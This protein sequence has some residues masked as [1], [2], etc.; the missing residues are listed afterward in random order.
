MPKTHPFVH[1]FSPDSPPQIALT[2]VVSD[3]F[4][5]SLVSNKF[6]YQSLHSVSW[7]FEFYKMTLAG[8]YGGKCL[9]NYL[10][11]YFLRTKVFFLC[12]YGYYRVLDTVP[13]AVSSVTLLCIHSAYDSL[14]LLTPP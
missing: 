1:P 7:V 6:S 3:V 8:L 14:H 13:C 12:H 5:L 2:L 9:F 10:L 4:S 11:I